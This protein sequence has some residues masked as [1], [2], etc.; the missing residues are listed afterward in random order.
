MLKF[1]STNVSFCFSF[2]YRCTLGGG[3]GGHTP[4]RIYI[5]CGVVFL[6]LMALAPL[7]PLV[8]P[9]AMMYFLFCAPLW[10]RNCI[11]I[12]RPMFDTGGARWPFLLDVS[13]S[14]IVIAQI[15]LATLMGFKK[16]FGP[17]ILVLFPVIPVRLIILQ[18]LRTNLYICLMLSYVDYIRLYLVKI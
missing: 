1:P 18:L 11:F 9:A 14:S 12:Y 13:I 3:P 8:A 10:R 15:L 4:Y 6:C 5:D 16:A 7:S 2:L 17:C